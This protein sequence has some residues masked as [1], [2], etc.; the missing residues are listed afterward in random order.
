M[1]PGYLALETHPDNPGMVRLLSS[2]DNPMDTPDGSSGDL[3]L[4]MSFQ[5]I[6]AAEMHGHTAM[7]HELVDINNHLYKKS[8]AR[9]IGDLES[10][11]LKHELIWKDPNLTEE[12]LKEMEEEMEHNADIR[13]R[14][15]AFVKFIKWAAIAILVFNL[16]APGI[17]EIMKGL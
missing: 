10:I 9:A 1:R 7:R 6:D 5:D 8:L 12:D 16:L 17:S 3:R 4:V 13:S 14:E 2:Y 11:Q 15:A